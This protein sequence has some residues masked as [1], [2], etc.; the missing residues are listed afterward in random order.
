MKPIYRLSIAVF[1]VLFAATSVNAQKKIPSSVKESFAA[2]YPDVKDVHWQMED[3]NFEGQFKQE[4]GELTAAF[5]V[6]GEWIET[7]KKLRPRELSKDLMQSVRE[8]Y[9]GYS[10]TE[11]EYVESAS[12]GNYHELELKKGSGVLELKV[13]A[14][15][16]M[17]VEELEFDDDED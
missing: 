10:I 3:G 2:K 9:S 14:D 16:K 15:G 4:G 1:L 11:A 6:E 13:F 12:E 5:S 8:K 17:A 7:E